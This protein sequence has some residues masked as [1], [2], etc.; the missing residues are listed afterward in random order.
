MVVDSGSDSSEGRGIKSGSETSS[1]SL[2]RLLYCCCC[3][4]GEGDEALL[5]FHLLPTTTLCGAAELVFAC[6][7]CSPPKSSSLERPSTAT[8]VAARACASPRSI[9]G[10]GLLRWC[11][12]IPSLPKPRLFPRRAAPPPGN[13][14]RRGDPV[15]VA[16]MMRA[17][18]VCDAAVLS[19]LLLRSRSDPSLSLLL[20]GE[21]RKK[22]KAQAGLLDRFL[23]PPRTARNKQILSKPN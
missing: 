12:C 1:S 11:W 4:R 13:E 14:R 22:Y 15:R 19:Q 6:C 5:L 16:K 17:V 18:L 20:S 21:S 2:L 7:C 23:L 3:L 8:A 9:P 10:S